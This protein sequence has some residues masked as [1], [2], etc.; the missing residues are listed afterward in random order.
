MTINL[1]RLFGA[2]PNFHI[3]V[4]FRHLNFLMNL[5]SSITTHKKNYIFISCIDFTEKLKTGQR[6][7]CGTFISAMEYICSAFTVIE[8]QLANTTKD[9]EVVIFRVRRMLTAFS[10]HPFIK[11]RGK[12]NIVRREHRSGRTKWSRR[13][14]HRMR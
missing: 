7:F 13:K 5:D 4:H 1:Y 11:S 14:G 2:V 3:K 9:R 12:K 8:N 6:T 10:T